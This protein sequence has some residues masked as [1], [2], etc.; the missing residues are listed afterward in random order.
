MRRFALFLN[1]ALGAILLSVPAGTAATRHAKPAAM[2]KAG[3]PSALLAFP[4]AMGWAATTPGGRGGQV[5]KV[6]T[7]N[8]DGPGSFLAA[9]DAK[10]PRIVVF[11]VGG[12]I[13]LGRRNI[14]VTEPYLTVAGQTAPSPGITFIRGGFEVDTHDVVVQNI[15]VRVGEAGFPKKSGWEQDGLSTG[16]G[17][18]DVIFDHNSVTWA[19]DENMSMS[20]QRFVG[21]DPAQWREHTSHRI[22]FSNNIIAEGLAFATHYKIEHS[23]GSLIHDNATDILLAD[24]LYAHNYERNPLLKGG[25]EAVIVNDLIY[26]PGQRAIHYNLMAQEWGDHPWQVGQL[27]VVGTVLREGESTVPHLAF[28]EIGGYGDLRYYGKDNIA[29]NQIGEPIPM[30]GRYT[31]S[32]AKIVMEKKPPIWPPY[33]TV[34]P[35]SAVQQYVLHNAGARIWDRDYDDVRLAADVAEGRGYIINSENDIHGYPVQKPTERPFNPADW[36]LI[37]MTPKSPAVLDSSHKAEGT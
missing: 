7:L 36:N 30:L 34:M 11:E 27:S 33:V 5:I 13:D 17:A 26:D 25:T 31:T 20:G 18:H 28:L 14:K 19:T 37:D 6:T 16:E 4:G 24:N 8:A 2:P 21:N 9:I 35:A 29:V 3:G 15:R 22:T 32:P 1:V 10:G 12:V 23:K